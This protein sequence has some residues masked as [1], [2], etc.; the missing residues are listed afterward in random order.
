MSRLPL[1]AVLLAGVALA[2]TACQSVYYAAMESVGREKRHILA[3]RVEDGREA[4]EEAQ[5]QFKTTLERFVELTGFDGGELEDVYGKLSS[6]FEDCEARAR[7]VSERIEAIDDVAQDLFAEWE[8]EIGQISSAD[9][10]RK[11]GARLADTQRQYKRLIGAMRRAES[12]MDPVLTAFR[13]QVLFLKHNLN[14]R[15]IGSLRGTVTGIESDVQA[16]VR[17]MQNAI[18]EA[19]RFLATVKN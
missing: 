9:L 12:R 6:E 17:D 14:A 2:A 16:L 11:S 1:A 7:E 18:A 19:D 8:D 5:E 15:A 3:G 13:D 10:R 4:Q